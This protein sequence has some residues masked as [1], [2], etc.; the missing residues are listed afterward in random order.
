MSSENN[1]P[2]GLTDLR[3]RLIIGHC[4]KIVLSQEDKKPVTIPFVVGDQRYEIVIKEADDEDVQT[5]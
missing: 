3:L 4:E 2:G 1:Y 5:T